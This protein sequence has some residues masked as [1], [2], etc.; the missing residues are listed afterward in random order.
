MKNR[1]FS[2]GVLSILFIK[3]FKIFG[4]IIKYL[5]NKNYY[6]IEFQ[7]EVFKINYYLVI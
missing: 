4:I 5:D 3:I 6:Y 1:I 2:N 7:K